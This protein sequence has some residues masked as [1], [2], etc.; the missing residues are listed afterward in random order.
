MQFPLPNFLIFFK[1][2]NSAEDVVKIYKLSRVRWLCIII[3]YIDDPNFVT[4]EIWSPFRIVV[5]HT[6]LQCDQQSRTW[7]RENSLITEIL[8]LFVGYQHT[9]LR[10][11]FSNPRLINSN[12]F[13]SVLWPA[14][15]VNT[16]QAQQKISAGEADLIWDSIIT[17]FKKVT[18]LE[19]SIDLVLQWR[20]RRYIWL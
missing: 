13:N 3:Q 7:L 20:P 11:F 1:R 15:N 8:T 6:G 2:K 19:K 18:T 17:S 12:I 10:N 5:E 9:L 4:W 16:H 14:M